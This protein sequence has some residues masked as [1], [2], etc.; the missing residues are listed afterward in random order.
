M[1]KSYNILIVDDEADLCRLIAGI[2]AGTAYR[3]FQATSGNEAFD[4]VRRERID[5]VLSDIRMANGTGIELL[6][7]LRRI[8]PT[9]PIVVL[10]TGY[11][12]ISTEEI[13]AKGGRAVL[14]K[15]FGRKPLLELFS[16][17]IR[18][19]PDQTAAS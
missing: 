16:Q 10:M 13:L 7:N 19:F 3:V 9:L 5:I 2:L 11:A 1:D 4:L 6:E 15:P 17:I 14:K 12:D 8:D 18:D